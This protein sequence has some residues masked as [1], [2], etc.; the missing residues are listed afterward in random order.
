MEVELVVHEI[1]LTCAAGSRARVT[2]YEM[3]VRDGVHGVGV[4]NTGFTGSM[5]QR[6]RFAASRATESPS[7]PRGVRV[8]AGRQCPVADRRS[9]SRL[10]VQPV[11]PVAGMDTSAARDEPGSGRP[12]FAQRLPNL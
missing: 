4:Y 7:G 3:S 8:E 11:A 10:R 12:G 5:A 9:V 2:A 1:S 6:G